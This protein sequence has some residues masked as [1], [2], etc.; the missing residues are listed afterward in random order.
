MPL[1]EEQLKIILRK[2]DTNGDGNVSRKELKVG[3]KRLDVRFTFSKAR[4][5]FRYADANGDGFISDDEIN[6]LAKHVSKW[7]ILLT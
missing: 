4:R 5:A 2:F 7:G 1:T 6:E 3:F